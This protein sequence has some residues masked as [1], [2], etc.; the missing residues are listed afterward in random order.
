M[1]NFI[2]TCPACGYKGTANDFHLSLADECFCPAER[3]C[4]W[5]LL[6]GDQDASESDDDTDD[7]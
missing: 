2:I 6:Y 3:G 5:F 4:E 1:R 7:E